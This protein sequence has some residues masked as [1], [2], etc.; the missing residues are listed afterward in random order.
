MTSILHSTQEVKVKLGPK[1]RMTSVSG[2][3]VQKV[4]KIILFNTCVRYSLI[5][6]YGAEGKEYMSHTCTTF[7]CSPFLRKA[8]TF[9]TSRRYK[10][11]VMAL[12]QTS[13][14]AHFSPLRQ[15]V[16]QKNNPSHISIFRGFGV[17]RSADNDDHVF[18]LITCCTHQRIILRSSRFTVV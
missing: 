13:L 15:V 14:V 5:L 10:S 16:L 6:S 1:V 2:Q 9:P 4:L 18:A 7:R 8:R 12:A 3:R 11:K 17:Q